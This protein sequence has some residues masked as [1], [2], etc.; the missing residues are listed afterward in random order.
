VP[1]KNSTALSW[2][3]TGIPIVAMSVMVVWFM[4]AP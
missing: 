4:V 2:S 3:L 1:T